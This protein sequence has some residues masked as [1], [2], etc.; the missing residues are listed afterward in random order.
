[1]GLA[2]IAGR[3]GAIPGRTFKINDP[4]I[5]ILCAL[6]TGLV[7]GH[8]LIG[9]HF[10]FHRGGY[11]FGDFFAIWTYAKLAF[12]GRSVELY[13]TSQMYAA[14]VALGLPT[15]EVLG[16]SPS[17]GMPFPFPYAP[18]FILMLW[19]L[20]VL[21][22]NGAAAIW[23]GTTVLLYLYAVGHGTRPWWVIVVWALAA[24]TSV[25]N[26]SFGQSG[27]LSA[28]LLIGGLRS[29]ERRPLLA[30]ILFGLLTYKPQFGIF[31]P[32]ALVAAGHWKT[33]A[34]AFMTVATLVG[35]ATMAFGREIWTIW[36]HSLPGYLSWYD[37]NAGSRPMR[38]SIRDNLES[39]GC[40]PHFLY[41]VQ[42]GAIVGAICVVWMVFRRGPREF[43]VAALIAATCA[44]T[45]HGIVYDLP[46]LTGAA[47][48]YLEYRVRVAAQLTLIE[49]AIT[50]LTLGFP[51]AT[52]WSV[53]VPLDSVVITAFLALVLQVRRCTLVAR[54]LAARG[55]GCN[56]PVALSSL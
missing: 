43:A 24:P 48:L 32:V 42:V 5:G 41:L 40:P 51:V 35:A 56:P 47:L 44:V 2:G 34:A 12:A 31:V 28:A 54:E 52:L 45:P 39:L 30:G 9:L 18:T 8:A 11:A 6:M 1:M 38:F 14:Q 50:L 26:V 25:V 27:F 20:G 53:H 49:V 19:P 33:I 10:I 7:G 21:S 22:Y 55:P 36:V 37:H 13:D 15:I 4:R 16:L 23:V 17:L 29:M 46:M 3:L